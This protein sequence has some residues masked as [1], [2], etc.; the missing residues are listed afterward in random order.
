MNKNITI[1]ILTIFGFINPVFSQ[2]KTAYEE[3]VDEIMT[4][5]FEAIGVKNSLIQIAKMSNNWDIVKTSQDFAFKCKLLEKEELL[6]IIIAT[7]KRLTD[8]KKLKTEIDFKREQDKKVELTLQQQIE[9]REKLARFSDISKIREEI[10][11][12]FSEWMSKDEFETELEHQNR[13]SNKGRF[14]DSITYESFEKRIKNLNPSKCSNFDDSPYFLELIQYNADKKLYEIN[15]VSKAYTG[16]PQ[17]GTYQGINDKIKD[18][19]YIDVQVAK[20]LKQKSTKDRYNTNSDAEIIWFCNKDITVSNNL[21]EWMISTNGYF[22]PKKYTLFNEYEHIY[23]N[24]LTSLNRISITAKEFE[25][26][27]Y[28]DTEHI[29]NIEKVWLERQSK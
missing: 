4:E 3:K 19:I 5:M 13:I 27:D 15:L 14:L 1:L 9:I 10:K 23:K 17:Y 8:A 28:F 22:V 11:S 18:S 7:D 26:D 16:I 2:S 20:Q 21:D 6:V 29:I 25:L 12:K 24:D